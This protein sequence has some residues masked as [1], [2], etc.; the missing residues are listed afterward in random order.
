[1][2]SQEH[3]GNYKLET[4][5]LHMPRLCILLSVDCQDKAKNQKKK[6]QINKKKTF[7]IV[8]LGK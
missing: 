2:N 6:K 7:F 3:H 1:M 4:T 8:I 5:V